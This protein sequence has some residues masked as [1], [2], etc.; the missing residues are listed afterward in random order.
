MQVDH[1]DDRDEAL[2]AEDL[3]IRQFGVTDVADGGTVHEDVPAFQSTHHP[4]LAL[5]EVDH[6]PVLCHQGPILRHPGLHREGCV[7]DQ[8]PDLPVDRQ[9]VAGLEHVV[10]VQQLPGAGVSGHVDQRVALV[11]H[12][13]AVAG[14]AVDHAVHRVLVARDQR[15]GQQHHVPL[16]G[17][18]DGVLVVGDPRQRA[19]RLPLGAG[20]DD[21]DLVV[22]VV[23]DLFEVDQGL[24]GNLEVAEFPRDRHVANHRAAD[25]DHF[26]VM[27][28]RGVHDL[29]DP[30]HMGR[31]TGDD[32]L[33]GRGGEHPLDGRLQ[34]AFMRGEARRLG[35]RGIRHEQVEPLG[36]DPC[37]TAEVG[38][39][40][41]K[42]QLIHLEVAGVQ[43]RTG[44]AANHHR[45]RI[46]DRVVDRQEFQV[47]PADVEPV[48][49]GDLTQFGVAEPVFAQL[50]AHQRQGEF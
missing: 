49:L 28:D 45:Q 31:E 8:V 50:L 14:K 47:E 15:A 10:A 24:L 18:H 40:A 48:P 9:H 44:H 16:A 39:P 1:H 33:L 2:L 13:D 35:V 30:M 34:V 25:V 29:L 38:E 21:Q 4:R 7:G 3:A 5:G 12:A 17:L 26:A 27:P 41:V 42:G 23:I 19:Q 37:E 11:H 36:A 20:R 43:H 32:Q 6:R 22:A 46:G